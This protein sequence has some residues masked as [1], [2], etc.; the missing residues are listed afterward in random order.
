MVQD[1]PTDAPTLEEIPTEVVSEVQ[2]VLS[3]MDAA[4]RGAKEGEALGEVDVQGLK[5]RRTKTSSMVRMGGVALPERVKVFDRRGEPSLV[6]TVQL[7]HH[8]SKTDNT[9]NRVFFPRPP[10]GVEPPKPIDKTCP[11]CL[12][13]G[14]RKKFY[15]HYAHRQHMVILHPLEFEMI[16]EDEKEAV[17]KEGLLGQLRRMTPE[18][19]QQVA[20]LFAVENLAIEKPVEEKANYPCRQCGKPHDTPQGRGL[21][22][23]RWCKEK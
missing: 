11:I 12:D 17:A 3:A 13:K 22:E 7:G 18:E 8:L 9:G 14:V 5:V 15:S 2:E 6:P 20:T 16:R 4:S 19:R 1:A 21:H 10:A 23:R